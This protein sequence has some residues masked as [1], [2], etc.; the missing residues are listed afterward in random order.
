ME[1]KEKKRTLPLPGFLCFPISYAFPST[2][3]NSAIR[4]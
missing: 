4:T 1:I 2:I 3:A